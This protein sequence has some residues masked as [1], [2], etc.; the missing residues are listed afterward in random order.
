M[1]RRKSTDTPAILVLGACNNRQLPRARL[2]TGSPWLLRVRSQETTGITCLS[3]ERF[4]E[5][6]LLRALSGINA[7]TTLVANY[8][9][10]IEGEWQCDLSIWNKSEYRKNSE[11]RWKHQADQP[12]DYVAYEWQHREDRTRKHEDTDENGNTGRDRKSTR[13]NSSHSGENRMPS[14]A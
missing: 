4:L 3:R 7:A 11:C 6:R 12:A 14:S 9:G 10:V 2:D 13:L 8:M 5:G 1:H